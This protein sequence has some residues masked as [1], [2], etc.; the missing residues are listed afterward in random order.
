MSS[1]EVFRQNVATFAHGG[2]ESLGEITRFYLAD[3]VGH[4]PLL[5]I[6]GD[7]RVDSRIGENFHAVLEQG[8]HDED[9]RTVLGRVQIA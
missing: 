1:R 7:F 9:S 8:G 5:R 3:H 2:A 4:Y 6:L